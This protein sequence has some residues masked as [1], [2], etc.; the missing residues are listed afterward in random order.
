MMP[1]NDKK[2]PKWI[3]K[4]K[5]SKSE[6]EQDKEDDL[7]QYCVCKKMYSDRFMIQCDYCDEWYHGSCVNITVTDA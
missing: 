4:Y 3:N 2:V 5:K 6:E 1:C 7:K